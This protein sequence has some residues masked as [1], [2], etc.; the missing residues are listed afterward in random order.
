MTL[1]T[2]M[3]NSVQITSTDQ[4]LST[5]ADNGEIVEGTVSII[6]KEFAWSF[7]DN[8]P[9]YLPSLVRYPK[10]VLYLAQSDCERE[11]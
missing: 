4:S 3:S 8:A 7:L 9:N 2:P 5:N 10:E 6:V 1:T 11:S